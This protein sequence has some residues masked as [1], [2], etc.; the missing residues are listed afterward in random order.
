MEDF[1]EIDQPS[2]SRTYRKYW[3]ISFI[4]RQL[5]IYFKS[6]KIQFSFDGHREFFLKFTEPNYQGLTGNI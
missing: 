3:I 1:F 6:F 2:L 4:I 5:N